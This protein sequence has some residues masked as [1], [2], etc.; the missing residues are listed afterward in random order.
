MA[1]RS[2]P[3]L[4]SILAVLVVAAVARPAAD[5]RTDEIL[6]QVRQAL[7]GE[8]LRTVTSLALEGTYRRLM[9][10]REMSGDLELALALPDRFLRVETFSFDPPNRITR[11]SGFS[12][13]VSLDG[14]S[15]GGG[16]NLF[17]G[18]PGGPGGPAS[19]GRQPSPEEMQQRRLRAARRDFAR[20][21]AALLVASPAGFP[22]EYRYAG[23]AESDDGKADVLDVTGPEEF[24]AKLLVDETTH[25]PLVLMFR[26][27]AP[28]M[29]MFRGRRGE[30]PNPEEMERR[31]REAREAGP[32]PQVDV[33]WFLGEHRKVDGV[34]LPRTIRRA[35]DGQTVEEWQFTGFDVN[36]T[37]KADKFE[38]R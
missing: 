1:R 30:R 22:L 5:S 37:F 36:P 38:K 4:A 27:T 31:M 9:G 29:Q 18:A 20:V 21:V 13:E 8:K 12:G 10:D 23:Q 17:R 15:G 2:L 7:G 16:A 6:A 14:T 26:D 11:Y 32:P 28:R 25:L 33:Q 35:V 24:A 34:L 19:G 3:A